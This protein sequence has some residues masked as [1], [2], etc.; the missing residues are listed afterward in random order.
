MKRY[1][2]ALDPFENAELIVE[3]ENWHKGE[4][5][6]SFLHFCN[7]STQIVLKAKSLANFKFTGFLK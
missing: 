7:Y 5:E 1:C 6:K 2:L 4:N 3:N